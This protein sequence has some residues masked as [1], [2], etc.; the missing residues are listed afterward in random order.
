M[1]EP[2][3]RQEIIERKLAQVVEQQHQ[4]EVPR[5]CTSPDSAAPP[6]TPSR[7]WSIIESHLHGSSLA[8]SHARVH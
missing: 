4:L 3:S 1:D 6:A 7:F 2:R 5:E 8:A